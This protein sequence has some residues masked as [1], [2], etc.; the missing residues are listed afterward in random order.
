MSW[1]LE[2][3]NSKSTER[4][5]AS[6]YCVQNILYTYRDKNNKSDTKLNKTLCKA[7]KKELIDTILSYLLNWLALVSGNHEQHVYKESQPVSLLCTEARIISLI[8]N[9]MRIYARRIRKK[10]TRFCHV[11]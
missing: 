3:I 5:N 4:I 8:Q 2:M 11:C 7:H 6:H 9:R 10:L 1:C